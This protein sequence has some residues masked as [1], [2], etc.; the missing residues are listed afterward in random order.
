MIGH[1][2]HGKVSF[3]PV[4][5]V[6]A[7]MCANGF[8]FPQRTGSMLWHI[9]FQTV[10]VYRATFRIFYDTSLIKWRCSANPQ[11][12]KSNAAS[13]MYLEHS[14][15]TFLPLMLLVHCI[16]TLSPSIHS[17]RP[18]RPQQ[19]NQTFSHPWKEADAC[20]CFIWCFDKSFVQTAWSSDGQH[21]LPWD[22]HV[23]FRMIKHTDIL[24]V[25]ESPCCTGFH[26][27]QLVQDFFH[28]QSDIP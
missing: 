2:T 7:C 14:I 17:S 4:L 22:G 24:T 19:L 27:S 28:Q 5:P 20:F 18:L 15:R 16:E 23:N 1:M 8:L 6:T 25:E 21:I 26:T 12:S 10:S 9:A 11:Q 3:A 13:M